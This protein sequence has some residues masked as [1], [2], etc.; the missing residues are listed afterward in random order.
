MAGTP[1]GDSSQKGSEDPNVLSNEHAEFD[2][3]QKLS[4]EKI[5]LFET[6]Y[7]NICDVD[8]YICWLQKGHLKSLPS[9]ISLFASDPGWSHVYLLL[10]STSM[11][12]YFCIHK[13][14]DVHIA[15]H[16]E[17]I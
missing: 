14:V 4:L 7:E 9:F 2:H 16:I 5:A 13:V 3:S 10:V 6:R 1:H 15:M 8:I 12:V 17:H 11:C